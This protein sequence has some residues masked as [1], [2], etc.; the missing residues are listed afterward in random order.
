M[1]TRQERLSG[2]IKYKITKIT[3][4]KKFYINMRSSYRP[5]KRI[6]N[7]LIAARNFF[8]YSIR[9]DKELL[10]LRNHA[11]SMGI[12]LD[13]QQMGL[14]NVYKNEILQWNTKTNLIS[15]NS[16][17]DIIKRHFLDSLTAL[18]F[19]SQP[20]CKMMDVGCG[21]GFPGIPLKIAQPDLNLFLLEANR[22]K[23]SFVKNII[24]L[25]NL[26][27]AT[28]LHERVENIITTVAWKES[29]DVL[30]SRATF[31]L[32][33]LYSLGEFFLA[34]GGEVIAFKGPEVDKEIKDFF[35]GKNRDQFSQLIQHDIKADFS[36]ATRKIIIIKK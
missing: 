28:V 7:L 2:M 31:T 11:W 29:V 4:S 6:L 36:E 9:M 16:S 10:A 8:C 12:A 27:H 25:L 20:G 22:K 30:I 17:R 32:S 1:L 34:P 35:S 33:E 5:W 24:R 14:F 13:D 23:V 21:A 19:I 15:E 26:S 3:V 18:R